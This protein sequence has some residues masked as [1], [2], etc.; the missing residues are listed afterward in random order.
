MSEKMKQLTCANECCDYADY[1]DCFWENDEGK[2]I[3]EECFSQEKVICIMCREMNSDTI[4][5]DEE[6]GGDNPMFC[7]N[8]DY[9]IMLYIDEEAYLF[10][11]GEGVDES[12]VAD[13]YVLPGIYKLVGNVRACSCSERQG[14]YTADSIEFVCEY[15]N[16]GEYLHYGYASICVNCMKDMLKTAGVL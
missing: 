2:L 4:M 1:E 12:R 3:C 7:V 5:D 11:R 14:R 16:M 15:E 13:G 6:R 9:Y 8:G 10:S